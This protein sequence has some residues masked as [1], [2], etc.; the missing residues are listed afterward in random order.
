MVVWG[1]LAG[2]W[3]ALGLRSV[4]KRSRAEVSYTKLPGTNPLP[5]SR[6]QGVLGSP[7]R[8]MD[9]GLVDLFI[10]R[11]HKH[12]DLIFWFQ[13]PVKGGCQILM[14]MLSLGAQF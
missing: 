4:Y 9:Q 8:L 13:G 1:G 2:G 11:P 14:S 12:K 5:Q 10:G 3:C 6:G 7:A